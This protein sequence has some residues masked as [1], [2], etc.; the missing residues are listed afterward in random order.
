MSLPLENPSSIRLQACSAVVQTLSLV[1]NYDQYS[2]EDST[3]AS[4]LLSDPLPELMVEVLSESG[5][6]IY[7]LVNG[8][9]ILP[10]SARVMLAVISSALTVLSQVSKTASIVLSSFLDFERTHQLNIQT[11][12]PI[13]KL[14]TPRKAPG[15]FP[16]WDENLAHQFL[17]E[18]ESRNDFDSPSL[19]TIIR[20]HDR[21]E[22]RDFDASSFVYPTTSEG[23]IFSLHLTP[24]ASSC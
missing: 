9:E 16:I 10:N 20:E 2:S 5:K 8:C 3:S 17:Q 6:A 22:L 24:E 11:D 23:S 15:K 4:R 18:M 12:L 1:L 19:E 21:T 14:P 7:S 13:P